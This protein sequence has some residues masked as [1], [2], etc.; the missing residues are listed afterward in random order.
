MERDK[1][2]KRTEVA[3]VLNI[4]TRTVRR[5]EAKGMLPVHKLTRSCVRYRVSDVLKLLDSLRYSKRA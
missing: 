2:L 4:S 1:L 3:D 5:W